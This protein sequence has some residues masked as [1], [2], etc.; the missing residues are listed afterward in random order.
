[1]W[2]WLADV[3]KP[4]WVSNVHHRPVKA[5]RT[6]FVALSPWRYSLVRDWQI[7]SNESYIDQLKWIFFRST[8]MEV[9]FP[10]FSSHEFLSNCV[11]PRHSEGKSMPRER[12]IAQALSIDLIALAIQAPGTMLEEGMLGGCQ[13][14]AKH[15]PVRITISIVQLAP[16]AIPSSPRYKYTPTPWTMHPVKVMLVPYGKICQWYSGD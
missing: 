14:W 11:V 6:S 2:W 9:L 10:P 5:L 13:N 16:P 8:Q 15:N 7:N 4:A 3:K 1:M 12:A